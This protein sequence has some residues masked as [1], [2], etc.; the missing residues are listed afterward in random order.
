MAFADHCAP[1]AARLISDWL[2]HLRTERRASAKTLEAYAT[3]LSHFV[4]F[5]S[6]HTAASVDLPVL[7]ELTLADLRGFMAH[8]RS[9]GASSRTLARSLS[10]IRGLFRYGEQNGQLQNSAVTVIR[11]PRIPHSVP[12]PLGEASAR[13]VIDPS[14]LTDGNTPQWINA[15][16]A[17]V[18]TLLYACGLRISEALSLTPRSAEKDMLTIAGK[19]GK[20]RLVPK[21]PIAGAAIDNYVALCPF[22]LSRDKALFRG[23]KGGPLNARNIQLLLQRLRSGLGLSESATPHALRHSFATHLLGNGADLRT[24][25]ELLGHSSLSTTQVYTEVDGSHIL[26]QYRRAHPRS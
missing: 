16:D 14:T 2:Q 6:Q 8:R 13:E 25:Q 18:L 7:R 21:L 5:L 10:A 3:D 1:D 4:G 24:I 26:E 19:G 12:K 17:A 9:E 20:S 15:R 23:A 22:S 11:S